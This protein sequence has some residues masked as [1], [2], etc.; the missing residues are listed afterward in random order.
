MKFIFLL[1]ILSLVS[2]VSL[3]VATQDADARTSH[4]NERASGDGGNTVD[5]VNY[6]NTDE[7]NVH[8]TF[9]LIAG[10]GYSLLQQVGSIDYDAT[11]GAS[12]TFKNRQSL[13]NA[14]VVTIKVTGINDGLTKITFPGNVLNHVPSGT[15]NHKISYSFVYDNVNPTF[16]PLPNRLNFAAGNT[17][18]ALQCADTHSTSVTN[19][20]GGATFDAE[21]TKTVIYTC[22]DA[23]GNTA[24]QSVSYSVGPADTTRPA[25]A[26]GADFSPVRLTVNDPS[27]PYLKVECVDQY[28]SYEFAYSTQTF[29]GARVSGDIIINTDAPGEHRISYSCTD[30]SGNRIDGAKLYRVYSTAVPAVPA[31]ISIASDNA[32]DTSLAKIGD[33]VTVTFDTEAGST[34]RGTIDGEVADGNVAGTTG[35]LKLTLDGDETPGVPLTFKFTQ[36]NSNGS[37]ETQTAVRGGGARTSVTADFVAPVFATSTATTD[38]TVGDTV[39]T[40]ST[41]C[42]DASTATVTNDA[43]SATFDAVGAKTVIYTCT[44]AA[45][46]TATQSV[47]YSVPPSIFNERAL[48]STSK[49]EVDGT[50]YHG[51]SR[52][53]VR[54][55]FDGDGTSV[56]QP[57][58]SDLNIHKNALLSSHISN[59]TDGTSSFYHA[60]TVLL[61]GV[62]FTTVT[63]PANSFTING[64]SNYAVTYAFVGDWLKPTFETGADF[65]TVEL[66]AGGDSPPLPT[67]QCRDDYISTPSALRSGSVDVNLAGDYPV[68]YTCTD[69]AGNSVTKIKTYRVLAAPAP[70]NISIES[71]N[72]DPTK[73][74]L[75]NIVTIT[76]DTVA[77]STVEGTIGGETATFAF[78]GASSTLTRTLDGTETSGVLTFSFVQ[79]TTAGDAPAQT[80]VKGA[81][82]TTSVTA[83][84]TKPVFAAGA[85]FSPV[86]LTVNDPSPP[87]LKVECV[88]QYRSYEF[89]YST[90]KFNNVRVSGDI[91]INTDAPGE[92]RISY[93]C[94]DTSGNRIDGA[95]LYRVYSTAV[96]AVPTDI[97]IASDNDDPTKAKSGDIVTITFDT[98][99]GSTV[100]GTID[101]EY[102][103]GNVTGTT[104]TLKLTL[105]GMETEGLLAFSFVQSNSNGSTETQTAVRGSGARTSVTADFVAPVFATSTDATDVAVGDTIPT[106]STLCTDANAITVTNDA[107]SATFDGVGAKTVIYTCTDA[108]GNTATQSVSYRV[109]P[110]IFNERV[111]SPTSKTEVDGTIY[112]NSNARLYFSFDGGD[113][114]GTSLPTLS[115]TNGLAL[116]HGVIGNGTNSFYHS[117]SIFPNF[118]YGIVVT[119]TYPANSFTIN[120]VSNDAVTYTYVSDKRNPTFQSGADFSTVE[121]T[122]GDESPTLPTLQ[123]RDTHIL[124]P[125]ALHSG[126]VDAN[127]AG[128]YPVEYT[129]TDKAGNTVTKTKTYRVLAEKP[130]TTAPAAPIFTN[131]TIIVST[132]PVTLA[133]TAEADSTVELFKGETSV[134]T[135]TA[136]TGGNFEF[137]GVALTGGS[138][139][140]TVTAT[141]ASSNTSAKSDA[142]VITLDTSRL[143]TPV[144]TTPL[145]ANNTFVDPI[146]ISVD[147]GEPVKGLTLEDFVVTGVNNS[148]KIIFAYGGNVATFLIETHQLRADTK[149]TVSL[150]AGSVTDSAGNGNNAAEALVFNYTHDSGQHPLIDTGTFVKFVQLN[151][152]FVLPTVACETIGSDKN[153]AGNGTVDVN[154]V[155]WYPVI[156]TCEDSAGHISSRTVFYNVFSP[157][158]VTL[159]HDL[160]S[161]NST[162][163]ATV[164]ITIEFDQ[165]VTG[166]DVGNL[167]TFFNIANGVALLPTGSGTSYTLTITPVSNGAVTVSII[168]STLGADDDVSKTKRNA[169]AEI[170]FVSDKESPTPVI[171]TT[172]LQNTTANPIPVSVDFGEPVNSF[173]LDD[174]AVTGV[175]DSAKTNLVYNGSNTA[176]FDIDTASLAADTQITVLLPAGNVTDLAGN[177]SIASNTLTFNY[178]AASAPPPTDTTAP[179]APIFTNSPATVRTTPV[180]L[181]GTAEADSTVE[182]FKGGTSV[183][184]ATATTGGNFEFAGVT[185]TEG[186][187]SFTVTATDASSNTSA[188]SDAL[189]ITLDT[190]RLI[191][192]VI[193]TLAA[194]NT[195]AKPIA[196]SVDFGEPVKGLTLEDFVVTGVNNSSKVTFAYGNN[197]AIFLINTNQLRADTQI[198]VSLPAGSVTDSAGTRNNAAETLVFNYTH[199]SGLHPVIQ[200]GASIKLVQ[201][202]SSFVLPTAECETVDGDRNVAGSGTVDVNT[203]GWYPVI[204][205]C[206]D[207][208]NRISSNTVLYNVFTPIGVTLSHNLGSA[209]STNAA[210]V[211][212]TIEFDQA[213]TGFDAVSFPEAVYV[214][215]GFGVQPTG[216]GTS[217]TLTI[218]PTS[219]GAVTVSIIAGALGA[220]DDVSKTKRNAAAKISFVSDKESPTP[221]ISTTAPQNT[222]ANPIPVSVDFGEPV[223]GLII[224]DFAVT[225]VEDSAKTNLVYNGSN[226]ATFDIDTASLVADTQI[227][228]LLPAGNV[229]DLAGNDSIAS[230]TLTFNYTAASAPPPADTAAPAAPIFTNSTIIVS[231]SPVILAGTAEADSTVELF[232]GETSV[233]TVTATTG[234]N[235]EFTGVA[236]TGGSNSFTVTATD[237]SSNVSAKS[238]ALVITLLTAPTFDPIPRYTNATS[239][240]FTGTGIDGHRILFYTVDDGASDVPAVSGGTWSTT[241][242]L[243]EGTFTYYVVQSEALTRQPS[244]PSPQ[245]I[246]TVDRTPPVFDSGVPDSVDVTQG[247]ST[248]SLS[249]LQCTDSYPAT[250][251]AVTSDTVNVDAVG[252]YP[253]VFT[254][255]DYAG[256]AVDKTITYRV[257]A[258]SPSDTLAPAAPI[259]TNSTATVRTTPVTLAGTAEADSTV[260]LYKGETFVATATATTGGNFEFAGVTLTEGSNSFTIA[261]TDASSNTS[262]KSG[263][264]VITL[265]TTDPVFATST[266]ATAVTLG[267]TIPTLSALCTDAN[268]ITVTNDAGSA[269]FDATGAKTVLYT[270]TDVAGNAATQSVSYS[271][272]AADTTD[273]VYAGPTRIFVIHNS[274]G[275]TFNAGASG[276]QCTDDTDGTVN[277]VTTHARDFTTRTLSSQ[278]DIR[279]VCT[280]AADNSVNFTIRYVIIAQPIVSITIEDVPSSTNDGSI[281]V[282]ITFGAD[283]TGFETRDIRV[284]NNAGHVLSGSGSSYTLAITPTRDGTITVTI[285]RGAAQAGSAI[286]AVASFSFVFDMTAPAFATST[287]ATDVAFGDTIPTLSA[288]CTDANTITVTN[289]AGSATFDA[290]GAKTVLYT[291]TDA[292]GNAATQSVSYSVAAALPSDTLAPAIPTFA[293]SDATV[294]SSPVRLVGTAEADSVVTL[295]KGET[296]V[297]T[298]TATGGTFEFTGVALDEGINSFTLTATDASSNVSAKSG[299]LVITLDTEA[300][301]IPT[302]ISIASDNTNTS[303]AVSGDI[304]TIT[305]DTEEGSIVKGTIGGKNATFTLVGTTGKLAITLDGT[306]TSGVLTFSFV[307]TDAAGNAAATQ[308]A[309]KGSAGTGTTVTA[310]VNIDISSTATGPTFLTLIPITVTF[311]TPVHGFDATDLVITNGE[312]V[313]STFSGSGDTYTF[314]VRPILG[315][316]PH[317]TNVAT[318]TDVGVSISGSTIFSADGKNTIAQ[319]ASFSIGYVVEQLFA[320]SPANVVTTFSILNRNAT[321]VRED[322]DNTITIYV[323][324]DV[325]TYALE[326]RKGTYSNSQLVDT[327]TYDSSVLTES[328]QQNNHTRYTIDSH[329]NIY[330][331]EDQSSQSQINTRLINTIVH[332]DSSLGY[333][334]EDVS[335]ELGDNT[336]FLYD[337]DGVDVSR[338]F[339]ITVVSIPVFSLPDSDGD[340]VIDTMDECLNSPSNKAV[341][342]SGCPLPEFVS[343]V[344]TYERFTMNM[345]YDHDAKTIT[346]SGNAHYLISG[347]TLLVTYDSAI[348]THNQLLDGAFDSDFE[349]VH[350]NATSVSNLDGTYSFVIED[351]YLPGTYLLRVS[352]VSVDLST[353]ELLTSEARG[354]MTLIIFEVGDTLPDGTT[355]TTLSERLSLIL[356]FSEIPALIESDSKSATSMNEQISIPYHNDVVQSNEVVT[357]LSVLNSDSYTVSR[358]NNAPALALSYGSTVINSVRDTDNYKIEFVEAVDI[359][360]DS[361]ECPCT[362]ELDFNPDL[363]PGSVTSVTDL[364]IYHFTD[365]RWHALDTTVSENALDTTVSDNTLSASVDSFSPFAIGV[366]TSA[367]VSDPPSDGIKKKKSGGS[368]DD[369]HKKPTFGISHLTY[370]QIVDNGF[371]FNGYSLTVT[372]NW[373]TDFHLTSSLIGETNTVKIKTYAADPLKW[374]NLYLGVPRLGDVSEAESEIH[375]VV[376]RNYTNPV[377]YD[378]DEI[379]HYQKEGLVNEN[380]TSASISKVKCQ[381]SDKDEKCYEFTINFTVMAPLHEE[382]VAISA[383][384]EKR[385]QHVTYINEGVEF[386]GTS[387]L[388]AHTAKLMQKKTNQGQAE[389]IEL[390]QQDRRYNVWEDQHGYLWTLNEYG[391]WTQVTAADFERHQDSTGNVMTRQNSNFASLIEQERQ[392]ALLVF[393]SGELISEL[394]DYFAYDYSNVTSDMSKSEKYAYELQLESE[395]AQKYTRQN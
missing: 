212:I 40:L 268:T 141:D 385:R 93:S 170:S 201:L 182:L 76:F 355:A 127:L 130:D 252:G 344:P 174:F 162:N 225:G 199:D 118:D 342:A 178:T 19:N 97:S 269:T 188:K 356:G 159:S 116:N 134:A 53:L 90:Q 173:T 38:V 158:G 57:P 34:V 15:K 210:T 92:H 176:T 195:H 343:T 112:H 79:S 388:D 250:I 242:P 121:L 94:T 373:H 216:S 28:R 152:S 329:G 73:A 181:A 74:K 51:F 320:D 362:I 217:Y 70:T 256:N 231:T 317:S 296:F 267:N 106:L 331:A 382:V 272:A 163:A 150:A 35:T 353:A 23:A 128:D 196:I 330:V 295:Y 395:R 376:S 126:S 83:D 324:A 131:S 179:A 85:D 111:S 200:G 310:T 46:N 55:H 253:V 233:A 288:L 95:K 187:N 67:L 246:Q 143:I 304:V 275:G 263:A 386:T 300:P 322:V 58:A 274:H 245:Q 102:A 387:L 306:E 379:N 319:P 369:W 222:T 374:I 16:G 240:T 113:G 340:G 129:C 77:G 63:Y 147:F 209:N 137:T 335:L 334:L 88:D 12:A 105:D 229:T 350:A 254:C 6:H 4:Y 270:C 364:K 160:G 135:V 114:H 71:D 244:P 99:A 110:T 312:L 14:F 87:Y 301:A 381:A 132:S 22:T 347:V 261:A 109:P 303:L 273:P 327:I 293:N 154:T 227:T 307:Q 286:N 326:L 204:Y 17:I 238:G 249:T 341:T 177:D 133:G 314:N 218:T 351:V 345:L 321:T 65:S 50:I 285:P 180:I 371:T 202:N 145:A 265:D 42:T 328:F 69:K 72:A 311:S 215:N 198:T 363:L 377:D 11:N 354:F 9:T 185:L 18:P 323:A 248:F 338:Y 258:A 279:F 299:A 2:L 104:G 78:N 316:I 169:A 59:G 27:P 123:C 234:G 214:I 157:I 289:D 389:I 220:A 368:S 291:C 284:T 149:I 255:T 30:T 183:T 230:N 333:L 98:E 25:F 348:F 139:S 120:G 33:I 29:N 264:L 287:D 192:P 190:S 161:A 392:K 228:V 165:A 3:G 262:A 219:N 144:I 308:T 276:V 48:S 107:G 172:A 68:E 60:Y 305:F 191:T 43:G 232:K 367:L 66:T 297:D 155:G 213:V 62:G 167:A 146:A 302:Y 298:A 208:A 13:S 259:F 36:S 365:G 142:L 151:S 352:E 309:V 206:E 224:K 372:D 82:S 122:V 80:V 86:R 339:S 226:T 257:A 358:A 124:T 236:L 148:S 260:T 384:D 8:F 52:V 37:T 346:A 394:D 84:F 184:T 325:T 156:Y 378:L 193:T 10:D 168:A 337:R 318:S 336:F 5:G 115:I 239:Y 24:T 241:H 140:F 251:P 383:M 39:P 153:V 186:S 44:D 89:A 136:T 290:E 366:S 108:A 313:P 96:P 61:R 41:L 117:Y 203:V 205:T 26:A 21:E 207:R 47:S 370:K 278:Y 194:N 247:D 7:V 81:G 125:S 103:D 375:L 64:V 349:I 189:V 294:S 281:E 271:V 235:F 393:D 32:R 54:F 282:S 315:L 380:N 119:V 243:S 171:S 45:G 100:S 101:G 221:V 211:P 277:A 175:E 390:T 164:P 56:V 360:S 1:V 166:F 138:N 197:V 280:D 91:I 31:N 283:V 332:D 223:N 391:T 292:A 49:T 75:G 20:A 359:K 237:A 361:D 357:T 266:D